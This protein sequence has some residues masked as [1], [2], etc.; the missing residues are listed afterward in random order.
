[1]AMSYT[2]YRAMAEAMI[3]RHEG[4]RTHPYC[5]SVGK[6]TIGVGRNL[7]DRGLSVDEVELLF[8]NDMRIAEQILD[9]WCENWHSFGDYQRIAL[10]SMAY[11]LGGP[12]LSKFV[13]MRVALQAR[14]F[15]TAAAEAL[16]SRWAKQ[17]GGRARDI[18]AMI[19]TDQPHA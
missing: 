16:N 8:K 7:T 12:R 17:V 10:M 9:I 5:D 15:I 11:N 2:P 18:A 19:K 6:M 4:V 13:K 1:M 14:D 3:K